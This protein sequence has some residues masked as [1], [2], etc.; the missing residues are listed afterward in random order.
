M[1]TLVERLA[2][3]QR[4]LRRAAANETPADPGAQLLGQQALLGAIDSGDRKSVV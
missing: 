4:I 1:E 2:N 3:E